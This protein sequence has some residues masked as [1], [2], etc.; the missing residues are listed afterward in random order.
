MKCP[1]KPAEEL[2]TSEDRASRR[3]QRSQLSRIQLQTLGPLGS[4]IVD[5]L[6]MPKPSLVPESIPQT[7]LAW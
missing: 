6:F 5:V 4:G 2:Q 7:A 3:E 1:R